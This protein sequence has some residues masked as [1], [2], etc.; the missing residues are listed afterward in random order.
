[1]GLERSH[2]VFFLVRDGSKSASQ[3]GVMFD[4]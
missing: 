4:K 1:M 2:S 3:K